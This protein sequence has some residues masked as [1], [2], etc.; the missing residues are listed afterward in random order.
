MGTFWKLFGPSAAADPFRSRPDRLFGPGHEGS[1]PAAL[2]TIVLPPCWLP[3]SSISD[4]YL[5]RHYHAIR[6]S[7]SS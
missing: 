4:N 5:S 3:K 7:M 2:A 6:D 1:V